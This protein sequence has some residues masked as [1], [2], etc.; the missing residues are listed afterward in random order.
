MGRAWGKRERGRER[1]SAMHDAQG[2]TPKAERQKGERRGGMTCNG[3]SEG[4]GKGRGGHRWTPARDLTFDM[5]YEISLMS[6]HSIP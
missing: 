1:A 3:G 4:D 6:V 5:T 2:E